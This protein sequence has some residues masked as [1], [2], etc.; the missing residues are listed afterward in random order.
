[1]RAYRLG[2]GELAVTLTEQEAEKILDP[3]NNRSLVLSDTTT[4]FIATIRAAY[5][6]KK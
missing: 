6:D 5:E 3:L 4:K 2:E 1:M